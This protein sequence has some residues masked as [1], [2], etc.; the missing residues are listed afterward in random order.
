MRVDFSSGEGRA[1]R[2]NPH[3]KVCCIASIEEAKIAVRHG[4]WAVG[5]VSAMPSGPG[6]ISE[7]AIAEIAASVP[8]SVS[9]FLLTSSRSA[10]EI[11]AQQRRCGV[12]TIQLCDRPAP[13]VVNELRDALPG[14]RLVQVVHVV[15][16]SAIDEARRAALSAHALLL[17]SGDPRKAIKELG[18]TGR[19]HD[20]SISRRIREIVDVPVFLAGGLTPDNVAEAAR[21]VNPFGVDVCSGL[22]TGGHLDEAK[23]A[24]FVRSLASA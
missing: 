18:G 2:A 22:R 23:V 5:L 6:V 3:F 24:R 17:D 20:W 12:N 11:I 7:Q 10:G 4:A 13:G 9:T 21:Q 1:P 14:I 19:V 8:S 15:D 16:E